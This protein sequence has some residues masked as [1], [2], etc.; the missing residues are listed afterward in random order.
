MYRCCFLCLSDVADYRLAPGRYSCILFFT[1]LPNH[2]SY[3]Y[4]CV[5]IVF[6]S[7]PRQQSHET[8]DI[9]KLFSLTNSETIRGSGS[10]DYNIFWRERQR[11]RD[12][13]RL[14]CWIASWPRGQFSLALIGQDFSTRRRKRYRLL[15]WAG[16]IIQIWP[17]LIARH[18][19]LRLARFCIMQ[20]PP[21][22]YHI[23]V[24]LPPFFLLPTYPL[25]N[26]Q[27]SGTLKGLKCS[28]S[29]P[30]PPPPP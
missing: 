15:P 24:Q 2:C 20:L 16:V 18:F 21:F 28:G 4:V 11:E 26:F 3:I 8:R 13:T 6:Q 27:L 29:L 22:Q 7:F 30:P 5:T 10:G 14:P 12:M 17:C 19:V 23:G 1:T 9:F 25:R